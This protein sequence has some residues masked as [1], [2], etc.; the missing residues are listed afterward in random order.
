MELATHVDAFLDH[1]RVERG[2]ASNTLEAYAADLRKFSAYAEASLQKRGGLEEL[3]DGDIA[4]FM[5]KLSKE[6]LSARSSARHLSAVKGFLRFLVKERMLE[7]D[8]TALVES[9]KLARKLPV[10]L[11]TAEID[12]L[13]ATPDRQTP[14]GLRDAAMMMLMYAA[15]LRVSELVS[16]RLGD[17]DLSRGTVTPLGKGSK[18]RI[19]PIADVAVDL[20]KRY[21]TEVRPSALDKKKKTDV[22]FVSPRGGALTRMGFWK[23]L[24]GHL[25]GA[26]ITKKISPHKL[27]HSFATHLVAHGADLRAV[28]TMLGH[29]KVATTE[30]YTHVARDHVRRAHAESHPRGR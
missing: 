28:Q 20:V 8:P 24:R 15:G 12:S 13:L 21:L 29:A 19:V 18:R 30:I 14:R 6:G 9:P 23:I 16:L 3:D 5:V 27:R 26:G 2:L 4:G 17:L 25:L 1:L 11:T 7:T 10:F 22:L